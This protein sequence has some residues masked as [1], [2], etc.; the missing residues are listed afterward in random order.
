MKA[1]P[2]GYLDHGS[3]GYTEGGA[4][5]DGNASNRTTRT[6]SALS[7]G[8]CELQQGRDIVAYGWRMG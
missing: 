6:L 1:T 2:D 4:E 7:Y 3:I 5:D 8:M